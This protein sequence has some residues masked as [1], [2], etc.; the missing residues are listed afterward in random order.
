EETSALLRESQIVTVRYNI[1]GATR[2]ESGLSIGQK[3]SRVTFSSQ[4]YTENPSPNPYYISKTLSI[5]L[6]NNLLIDAI[7][8]EAKSIH[9]NVSS[10]RAPSR[11]S[12]IS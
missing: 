1:A 11:K 12:S 6:K 2:R 7:R 5:D 3:D 8:D 10:P 4:D 9:L